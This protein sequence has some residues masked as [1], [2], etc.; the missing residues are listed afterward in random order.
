M[1]FI[2]WFSKLKRDQLLTGENP[3]SKL[4]IGHSGKSAGSQKTER[5]MVGKCVKS[6]TSLDT[7]LEMC[8]SKEEWDV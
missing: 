3:L 2:K 4:Y 5:L 1:R 6:Q 8:K 7:W